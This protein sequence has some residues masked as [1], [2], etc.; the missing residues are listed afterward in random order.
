VLQ[1]LEV[2]RHALVVAWIALLIGVAVAASVAVDLTAGRARGVLAFEPFHIAGHLFLFAVLAVLM[3]RARPKRVGLAAFVFVAAAVAQEY[4]QTIL[5][6]H[7]F[8]MDS[9]FDVA[10][11]LVGGALGLLAFRWWS[12]RPPRQAPSRRSW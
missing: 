5:P 3:A 7:R 2:A 12:R 4:A 11:D 1:A 9:A 8:T 10:V 6:G